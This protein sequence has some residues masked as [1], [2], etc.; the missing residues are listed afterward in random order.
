MYHVCICCNHAKFEG[1]NWRVTS[2]CAGSWAQPAMLGERLGRPRQSHPDADSA[3]IGRGS[4]AGRLAG[5]GAEGSWAALGR[6]WA[7]AGYPPPSPPG[8]P[9]ADRWSPSAPHAYCPAWVGLT[10]G[11]PSAM[12]WPSGCA[13]PQTPWAIWV[14]PMWW[15][16][17]HQRRWRKRSPHNAKRYTV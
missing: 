12:S 6:P 14:R 8:R 4:A 10:A 15:T 2:R 7:V 3:S 13:P 11:P 16:R 17:Y 5:R 1:A 9:G